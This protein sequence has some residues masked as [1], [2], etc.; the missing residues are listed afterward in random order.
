MSSSEQGAPAVKQSLLRLFHTA[1]DP[2]L[3]DGLQG[4]LESRGAASRWHR[5]GSSM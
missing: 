5:S 1:A 2:R 4:S 3:P